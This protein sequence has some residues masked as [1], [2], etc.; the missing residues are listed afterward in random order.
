MSYLVYSIAVYSYKNQGTT[1]IEIEK[2]D[3]NLC[4]STCWDRNIH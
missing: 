3:V 4:S 1:W 2:C